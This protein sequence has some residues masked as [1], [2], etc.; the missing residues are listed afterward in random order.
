MLDPLSRGIPILLP[1][2]QDGKIL[3]VVVLLVAIAL[4]SLLLWSMVA[5]FFVGKYNNV[6]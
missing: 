5:S 4:V 6:S 1:K 3:P 2:L